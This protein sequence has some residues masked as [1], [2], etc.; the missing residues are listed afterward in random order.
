ML[1]DNLSN[2]SQNVLKFYQQLTG[3]ERRIPFIFDG[4]HFCRSRVIGLD[5]T[6]NR[7]FT[8]YRMITWIVFLRMFWNFISSLLVKRGGFLSFL[9]GTI[10]N[11]LVMEIGWTDVGSGGYILVSNTSSN[12][13]FYNFHLS[14]SSFTCPGLRASGLMQRLLKCLISVKS[15]YW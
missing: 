14:E 2:V 5:M 1:Y 6:E 11:V 13:F 7:I 4:F 10:R 3:E 8:L 15:M 9:V 12:K